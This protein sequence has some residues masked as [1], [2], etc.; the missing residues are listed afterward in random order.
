M[1]EGKAADD[2]GPPGLT[3]A[4][5]ITITED[6]GPPRFVDMVAV[7]GETE[8]MG[9]PGCTKADRE[10]TQMRRGTP[11]KVVDVSV[12]KTMGAA[13][14]GDETQPSPY[15][16]ESIVFVHVAEV[17]LLKGRGRPRG[18]IVCSLVAGTAGVVIVILSAWIV[19]TLHLKTRKQKEETEKQI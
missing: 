3:L 4:E 5:V 16:D 8:D 9:P 17:Q 2:I 11:Y 18:T 13:H 7:E 15:P 14:V 10:E 1:L 12:L 19:L 6:I